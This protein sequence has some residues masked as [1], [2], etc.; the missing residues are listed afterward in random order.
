VSPNLFGYAVVGLA[1]ALVLASVVAPARVVA[2]AGRLPR[3]DRE[4]IA[5]RKRRGLPIHAYVGPNGSGKSVMIARDT[6]PT[7]A[8]QLWACDNPDHRHTADGVTSGVRRVV[9]TMRFQLPDGT[10]HPLWVPLTEWSQITE[11]E[12][13]DLILDEVGGAV[14]STAGGSDDIPL[15]VK[16]SLQEL[17]RRDVL[18]RWSAPSWNRASKVL[19]ETSQA[20][21]LVLGFAQVPHRDGVKFDGPHSW[22]GLSPDSRELVEHTCEQPGPHDH[23]AGRQWGARRLM[24]ARTFDANLFDEWTT[25][26]REKV[27]PLVRHLFWRPGSAAELHY[28]THAYVEKLAQVTAAGRC[29]HCGGKRTAPNCACPDYTAQRASTRAALRTPRPRAALDDEIEPAVDP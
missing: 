12:H 24:F 22:L 25:A 26:K 7:L 20:V 8:G 11:A 28:D 2:L 4:A 29:D 14:A 1:L 3:F 16:A 10:A 15:G 9:S 19:R 23:D 6:L 17:R 13:C 5:V 21:T 27:R 18:C